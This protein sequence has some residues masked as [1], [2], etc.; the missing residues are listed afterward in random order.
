MSH[1]VTIQTQLRDSVAIAA[2]CQRL[3]LPAPVLGTATLFQ[4]DV[5]GLLVKLPGWLYPVVVDTATGAV[6][7]DNY[8]GS[9]GD[10][11]HLDRFVQYYTVEKATIEARKQ[12]YA[13][14]EQGLDDGSIRL[15]IV[16]A[17]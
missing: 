4:A 6:H 11:R 14:R 3:A 9:W 7:Y 17:T 16:A 10:P 5:V 8:G 2:A 1:I 13:V 15:Q 12:G